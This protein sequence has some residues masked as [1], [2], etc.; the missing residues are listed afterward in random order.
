MRWEYNVKF[1]NED[2]PRRFTAEKQL[3]V[4]EIRE[5]CG[6]D[7]LECFNATRLTYVEVGGVDGAYWT[8]IHEPIKAT[9][10]DD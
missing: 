7:A 9:C 2:K 5:R 3:T 6:N 8:V 4:S 1:F 10:D